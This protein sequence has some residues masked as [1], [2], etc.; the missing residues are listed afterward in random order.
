MTKSFRPR[1][2]SWNRIARAALAAT[3]CIGVAG[4][5]LRAQGQG[6]WEGPW[7]GWDCCMNPCGGTAFPEISHAA[8]IPRGTFAGKVILWHNS[9]CAPGNT[10]VSWIWDPL[11]PDRISAF[12]QSPVVTGDIF[13]S[14]TSWDG[15]SGALVV[16]GANRPSTPGLYKELIRFVPALLS[17]ASGDFCCGGI[18]PCPP[19]SFICGPQLTWNPQVP[20]WQWVGGGP[21]STTQMTVDRF[22]PTVIALS[23]RTLT[24]SNPPASP[25]TIVG[26]AHLILGGAPTSGGGSSTVWDLLPY[27]SNQIAAPIDDVR[28]PPGILERYAVFDAATNQPVP[29]PTH[30]EEYPRGF[31][32]STGDIL[33]THDVESTIPFTPPAEGTK[34]GQ[35]WVIRPYGPYHPNTS[36]FEMW[37]AGI[38][39]IPVV[40]G[41]T[42][43]VDR[44]YGTAV[45]FHR[46]NATDQVLVFGGVD[47]QAGT[48][49]PTA[50]VEEFQPDLSADPVYRGR[51]VN[52]A[53]SPK[54]PMQTKRTD[55]NAVVLPDATVLLTGGFSSCSN[56]PLCGSGAPATVPELYDPGLPGQL[57]GGTFVAAPNDGPNGPT[58]RM[59]HN[60][61]LLLM[62]GSVLL[63]GGE[64][65][66]S[67]GFSNGQYTAEVYKPAYMDPEVRRPT[68][69][70]LSSVVVQNPVGL[71]TNTFTLQLEQ[72]NPG[73]RQVKR[74][75]LTRP[76]A[77][78]HFFDNDQRYVEL[79]F[80]P[81]VQTSDSQVL[82][83]T[84]LQEN[85]GPPGHYM[86]WVVTQ[87][88]TA[89]APLVPSVASIIQFQ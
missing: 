34:R 25:A 81:T 69:Q 36:R 62:D 9:T 74:V 57:G 68:F 23:K 78:T 41:G 56:P 47:F 49:D 32:M 55:F 5:P 70:L 45:L 11:S 30:M 85:L 24:Y 27:R 19:T 72:L 2:N 6:S 43:P 39:T 54:A 53:W 35:W 73:S 59:Y 77:V 13:C 58:A 18:T 33:M 52:G 83:V 31:Q 75:V 82:T 44:N 50:T 1:S 88:L 64:P 3:A 28:E 12:P 4:V 51:I 86:L 38:H 40:G 21:P 67:P 84:S 26:G 14:G 7:P 22:Y 71:N 16:A 66:T 46:L 37:L 17:G 63:A 10:I 79:N 87:E 29:L 48:P 89:G 61:A 42:V 20:A 60:V 76:G 65:A 80:T 15:V 8:L